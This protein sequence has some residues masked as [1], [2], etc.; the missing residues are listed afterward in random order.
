MVFGELVDTFSITNQN[1]TFHKMKAWRKKKA[2]YLCYSK[3]QFYT[4]NLKYAS[5]QMNKGNAIN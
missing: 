4:T 5:F 3:I 1:H 2:N